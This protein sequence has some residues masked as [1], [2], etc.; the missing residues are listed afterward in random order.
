MTNTVQGASA[1][2][3][4]LSSVLPASIPP[5]RDMESRLRIT[6]I[7]TREDFIGRVVEGIKKAPMSIRLSP[8]ILSVVDWSDPLNDPIRRQFIPV[9]SPLNVDHPMAVLDPMHE[10]KYSPVDGLIHR[11]PDRALFLATS[12]CPVYC[13]FCFRSYTVGTET[14]SVKKK[15]FIPHPKK[16]APRF[17][18][19]E[20]TTSLRDIV[21]S[22]GD[23]YLLEP[24]QVQYIGDRLLAMPH[25]RR[26]RFASKGL[27]VSPSRLLDPS[28]GWAET[29]M[30]LDRRARQAGKH[31]CI[32]TH[33]NH[34]NEITW[35]TRRGA[36]RL[37]EAGVTVRNQSVLLNGVNNTLDTMS[38]LVHA[39]GD[40]NIQPYY[41]YQGDLVPGAEDLRTP[42]RDGLHLERH[43]RGRIAGFY[44]PSFIL[45]LPAEGGKRLI[46]SV[47]S[48]DERLGVATLSAP[49]LRGEE[50]VMRYW[51]PLWSLGE[52][53]RREVLERCRE[54]G[55][56]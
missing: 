43:M 6:D 9:S 49:G 17:D 20:R 51:D 16:W 27:G 46:R 11:Y 5:Q 18:Y 48:Y 30:G 19:I 14:E 22:G 10:D 44:V 23:T 26:F 52:E 24:E 39:L 33:I 32:H 40:I 1:L 55:P 42:L 56:R 41:V 7:A 47:E 4:F 28:D 34:P 36:Q 3:D 12:I 21:I 31:M 50:T 29:V 2:L 25:I 53:A 35:V 15:K 45:D 37:Y 54:G 8:H 13:R 38:E